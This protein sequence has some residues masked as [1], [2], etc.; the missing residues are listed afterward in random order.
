[1]SLYKFPQIIQH[2]ASTFRSPSW[3]HG[4][5]VKLL[6]AKNSARSA[7]K[8]RRG[9][10]MKDWVKRDHHGEGFNQFSGLHH[11]M[12]YLSFTGLYGYVESNRALTIDDYYVDLEFF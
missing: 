8:L 11:I 1:M 2:V 9:S 12:Q 6:K 5:I 7:P 4:I 10:K 3:D